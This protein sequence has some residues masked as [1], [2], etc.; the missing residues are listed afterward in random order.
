M[1]RLQ[2][3]RVKLS[4]A[5]KNASPHQP[6]GFALASWG[7]VTACPETV[8][9]R[10]PFDNQTRVFLSRSSLDSASDSDEKHCGS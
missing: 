10:R 5:I 2:A 8:P 7:R 4:E 6:A 3:A 9:R 1:R